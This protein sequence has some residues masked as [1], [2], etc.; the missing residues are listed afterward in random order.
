MPGP[1]GELADHLASAPWVDKVDAAAS[2]GIRDAMLKLY[3][4]R[5]NPG[6]LW[7]WGAKALFPEP[8]S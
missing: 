5:L 6:A 8:S 3:P 4:N 1:L 2:Q 7:F